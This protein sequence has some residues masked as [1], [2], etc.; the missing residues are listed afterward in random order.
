MAL[1]FIFFNNETI[2]ILQYFGFLQIYGLQYI[3]TH[4]HTHA[5]GNSTRNVVVRP[6]YPRSR[7]SQGQETVLAPSA[8]K[9][10]CNYI[11][12]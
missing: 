4:I 2:K 8:D 12:R 7:D 3:C 6:F 10:T 5:R 1:Y 9:Q 11:D